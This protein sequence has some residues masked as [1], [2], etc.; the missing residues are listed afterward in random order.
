VTKLGRSASTSRDRLNY[1]GL[2]VASYGS[3][4]DL[5]H[6]RI[7]SLAQ[8]FSAQGFGPAGQ[9]YCFHGLVSA[10]NYSSCVSAEASPALPI[11]NDW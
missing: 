9:S 7:L 1:Q 2:H 8:S 11:L 6:L 5:E 3:Y 4:T 10:S